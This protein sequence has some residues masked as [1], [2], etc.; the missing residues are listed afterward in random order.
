MIIPE[1]CHIVCPVSFP[2]FII[3]VI[4]TNFGNRTNKKYSLFI[5][6]YKIRLYVIL[7]HK[8][9][10]WEDERRKPYVMRLFIMLFKQ[11]FT[12]DLK[13]KFISK[14]QIQLK[15]GIHRN[16]FG[17][18]ASSFVSHLNFLHIKRAAWITK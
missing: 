11:I 8:R 13:N 17:S 10:C 3:T 14:M 7:A 1:Y 9:D 2:L 12:R 18:E 4:L 16:S 6:G 5:V 15:H